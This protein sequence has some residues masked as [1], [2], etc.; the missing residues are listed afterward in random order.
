MARCQESQLARR[1]NDG[2]LFSQLVDMLQFY[3]RFE[4][5]VMTGNQLTNTEVMR[6]HEKKIVSLQKIIY[7]KFECLKE[8][9]LKSVSAIDT[10][11]NLIMYIDTLTN[12]QLFE[13]IKAVHIGDESNLDENDRMD[14][15]LLLDLIVNRYE[16]T[17]FQ[18]QKINSMPLYPTE[19]VVW[20]R[21]LVPDQYYNFESSLSLPK[22]NL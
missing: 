22:L 1:P 17:T 8:F 3:T 7:K 2:I 18:L 9:S 12:E 5:D 19:A 20:D 13:L 15:R 4:I 10:R 16:R 14:R 21:N 11:P 6:E